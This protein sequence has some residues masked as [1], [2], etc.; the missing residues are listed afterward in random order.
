[1]VLPQVVEILKNVH[2]IAE[3]VPAGVQIPSDVAAHEAQYRLLS[4]NLRKS[5]DQVVGEM[6]RLK[7]QQPNL[8]QSIEVI[9]RMLVDLDRAVNFSRVVAVPQ[10]IIVKEEVSRPVLVHDDK[11]NFTHTLALSVLTEK[12]VQELRRLRTERSDL[13]FK[14]DE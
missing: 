3:T 9:E 2:Q 14:L 1:M 12:L 6:R 10:E 11:I 7:T 5:L 4:S 8:K 13:K